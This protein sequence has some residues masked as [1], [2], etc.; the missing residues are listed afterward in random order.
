MLK[1]QQKKPM[2]SHQSTKGGDKKQQEVIK[3]NPQDIYLLQN[4]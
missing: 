2:T 1:A 3:L 4:N